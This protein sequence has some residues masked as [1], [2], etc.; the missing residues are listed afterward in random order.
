MN[1]NKD[2]LA[3]YWLRFVIWFYFIFHGMTTI[4]QRSHYLSC[5]LTLT[6]RYWPIG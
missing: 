6:C 3:F 4:F 5:D 1:I 2:I